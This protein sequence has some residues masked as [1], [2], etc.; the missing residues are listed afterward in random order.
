MLVT[1]RLLAELCQNYFSVAIAGSV[2]LR[3]TDSRCEL[4]C[5]I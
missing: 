1:T 4:D 3:C 5:S 2:V